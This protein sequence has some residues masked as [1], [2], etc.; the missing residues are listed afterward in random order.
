MTNLEYEEMIHWK[1]AEFHENEWNAMDLCVKDILSSAGDS[2]ESL[3]LAV[4]GMKK[5]MLEGD[6][7]IAGDI[8]NP[9]MTLTVRYYCDNLSEERKRVY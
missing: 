6:C 8:E 9:D 7:V 4:E 3:S 1:K 2:E 5:N